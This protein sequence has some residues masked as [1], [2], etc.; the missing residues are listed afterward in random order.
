[1]L[2]WI[3]VLMHH[4]DCREKKVLFERE[5][6]PG[7]LLSCQRKERRDEIRDKKDPEGSARE[8]TVLQSSVQPQGHTFILITLCA[9]PA[10]LNYAP[11]M[12]FILLRV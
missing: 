3:L 11:E 5:G 4:A 7:G 1:M 9:G 10:A 8:L 12:R 6:L 2:L